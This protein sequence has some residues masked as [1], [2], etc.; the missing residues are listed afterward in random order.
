MPAAREGRPA[1]VHQR[2]WLVV[3]VWY[4]VY[5]T[6]PAQASWEAYQRAGEEAYNRGQYAEAEQMFLAAVREAKHFGPQ[7]PRLDISLN[8]LALLRVLRGHQTQVRPR[9]QGSARPKNTTRQ[10]RVSRRGHQ[11][12]QPRTALQQARPGRHRQAR[13]SKRLRA[14]STGVRSSMARSAQRFKR[15][16]AALHQVR[17]P[18][19]AI[20]SGRHEGRPH[21]I[22]RGSSR[23]APRLRRGQPLQPPRGSIRRAGPQHPGRHPRPRSQRK[24]A[25][26]PRRVMLHAEQPH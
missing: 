4:L 3:C 20:A 7:D 21:S 5:W 1:V 17:P 18:R 24:R 26:S 6:A 10:A 12:R 25:P 2:L 9:P 22:Q 23:Q 16:R 11:Q 14:H 15:P 13:L 8:K 19:R